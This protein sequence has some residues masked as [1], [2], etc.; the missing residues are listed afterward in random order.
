MG[1][2]RW[3]R[4]IGVDAIRD[5]VGRLDGGCRGQV[6]QGPCRRSFRNREV[7]NWAVMEQTNRKAQGVLGGR[8]TKEGR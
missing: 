1:E 3:V 6:G 5:H 7:D 2:E 4:A 8:G